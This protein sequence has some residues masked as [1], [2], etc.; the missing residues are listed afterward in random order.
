M[1][2]KFNREYRDIIADFVFALSHIKDCYTLFE[3]TSDDWLALAAE[4]REEVIRTLADDIFYGLG[5][6]PSMAIGNS[7]V[8]YDKKQHIIKV[9]VPDN[10]IHVVNLI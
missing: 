5:S 8:E 2:V 1:G 9:I 4:E 3:M 10:V 7:R 6:E